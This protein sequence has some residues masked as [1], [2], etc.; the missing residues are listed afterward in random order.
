MISDKIKFYI[1]R[2]GLDLAARVYKKAV[3][4]RTV[5]SYRSRYGCKD[6]L[7]N[8]LSLSW[9][10][11]IDSHGNV[12]KLHDLD[13]NFSLLKARHQRGLMRV[14]AKRRPATS[15][16]VLKAFESFI[17]ER[18]AIG[19]EVL[20]QLWISAWQQAGSPQVSHYQSYHYAIKPDFVQPDYLK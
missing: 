1:K 11:V 19:S 3:N 13:K 9:A 10:L 14:D 6:C 20:A 7:K 15:T 8:P 4:S 12:D 2:F 5:T 17:I 16:E 18:L